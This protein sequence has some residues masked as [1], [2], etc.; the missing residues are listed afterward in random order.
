MVT[1]CIP[2][3]RT[4]FVVCNFKYVPNYVVR[5]RR[6]TDS[7]VRVRFPELP[8]FLKAVG[9]ER[10]P[11][12]LVTT[13][14]ELLERESGDSSLKNPDYDLRG[15]AALTTRHPSI[16]KELALTSPTSGSCSIGIVRWRTEATELLL[17]IINIIMFLFSL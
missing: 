11:L 7:E 5:P 4:Y 8:D 16:R 3:K 17:V 2:F 15:S 10:D 12:S 1:G 6:S 13:I 14:E 9:L